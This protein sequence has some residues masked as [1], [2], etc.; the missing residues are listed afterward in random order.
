VSTR[1]HFGGGG[2]L[3]D[4]SRTGAG[5]GTTVTAGSAFVTISNVPAGYYKAEILL[6]VTGTAE[7]QP[8]NIRLNRATDGAVIDFP[9]SPGSYRFIVDAF[10]VSATQN[11]RLQAVALSTTGAIYTG[12]LALT[13]IGQ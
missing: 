5:T 8:L 7:T 6:T 11:V 12:S 2:E 3:Y 1:F 13:K 9:S 4:V 10:K